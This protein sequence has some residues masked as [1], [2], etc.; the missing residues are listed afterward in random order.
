MFVSVCVCVCVCVYS[1]H[2]PFGSSGPFKSDN[3]IKPFVCACVCARASYDHEVHQKS[4][5]TSVQLYVSL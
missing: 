4:Q 2:K 3:I 1:N 5:L